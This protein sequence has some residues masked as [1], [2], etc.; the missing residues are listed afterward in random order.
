M[1]YP[2]NWATLKLPVAG[3]KIVDCMVKNKATFHLSAHGNF[4]FVKFFSFLSIWKVLN[5]SNGQ[6]YSFH[7]FKGLRRSGEFSTSIIHFYGSQQSYCSSTQLVDSDCLM[8][9]KHPNLGN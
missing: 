2:Q 5:L 9:Q 3:Q 4:F 7:Q 1:V 6:E 8:A